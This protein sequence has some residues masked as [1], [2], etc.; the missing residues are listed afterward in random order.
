[1]HTRIDHTQPHCTSRELY[2]GV[3]GGR[4]QG[5]FNGKI[6]VHKTAAQTD[7]AQTNKNLLLSE[8]ARVNSKPQL[9][10]FHND[11]RCRH[12]SSTGQLDPN[13]VFYLRAR[14]IDPDTARQLLTAAFLNDVI[15][16]VRTESIRDQIAE[17]VQQALHELYTLE[18]VL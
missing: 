12:G 11:V 16:H 2:A 8:T 14:G 4:A 5:V 18:K 1:M 3:L 6:C 7:A 9:E 13:A 15:Q 17:Q 10:I